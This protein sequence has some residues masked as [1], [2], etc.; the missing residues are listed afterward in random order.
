MTGL[1]YILIFNLSEFS[2]NK[3]ITTSKGIK[4]DKTNQ[5]G[6]LAVPNR[7]NFNLHDESCLSND[8]MRWNY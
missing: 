7:T 1:S 4:K 3:I 6:N 2:I 5:P 8:L